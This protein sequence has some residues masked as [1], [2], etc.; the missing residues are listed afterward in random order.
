[1]ITRS[2][3]KPELF[4]VVD[5]RAR[6]TY[7]GCNQEWYTTEWQR[8]SGCGPS[9][10][11]NIILY[12]SYTQAKPGFV[13][14]CSSREKCV[15][16]ME[17]LWE[18]VT[19][20]LAGIPTTQMFYEAM[21]EYTNAHGLNLVYHVFDV[22]DNKYPRPRLA[23]AVTF[24]ETALEKDVPV[25]FLN[26]SNGDEKK[27]DSWHWVTIISLEYSEAG[28][29]AFVTILDEGLIKKI[30]LALWYDTTTLGGGFVYFTVLLLLRGI[31][32]I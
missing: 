17:E 18:S 12:L 26:L 31:N 29:D 7:H 19:P 8:R 25:A 1:M 28:T 21:M 9:A 20:T 16:V 10:A 23:E 13:K 27:L 2:I 6:K 30:N 4:K 15:S 5:V 11:S 32:Q 24:I 3:S 14:N 22:P